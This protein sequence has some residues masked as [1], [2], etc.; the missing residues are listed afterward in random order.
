MNQNGVT[1]YVHQVCKSSLTASKKRPVTLQGQGQRSNRRSSIKSQV[2]NKFAYSRNAARSNI[3]MESVRPFSI[4]SVRQVKSIASGPGTSAR[5]IAYVSNSSNFNQSKYPGR[6]RSQ[7][8]DSWHW[9]VRPYKGKKKLEVP[10]S[11]GNRH[12]LSAFLYY[13]HYTCI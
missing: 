13:R 4:T 2:R 10:T 6:A 7:Y 11:G 5:A 1:R 9:Q 8:R 12:V 3:R